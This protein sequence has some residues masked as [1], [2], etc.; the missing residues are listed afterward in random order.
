MDDPDCIA[1]S[2]AETPSP[3]GSFTSS[4]S[5]GPFA[6]L[7]S[8]AM[9]SP[10]LGIGSSTESTGSPGPSSPASSRAGGGASDGASINAGDS[11]SN[12]RSESLTSSVPQPADDDSDSVVWLQPSP[13]PADPGSDAG[14]SSSHSQSEQ[15]PHR[16]FPL[17][18]QPLG[19][20]HPWGDPW[21]SLTLAPIVD[22]NAVPAAGV[23]YGQLHDPQR[24]ERQ[25]RAADRIPSRGPERAATT[26]GPRR[27]DELVQVSWT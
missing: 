21:G 14:G 4:Y 18:L 22:Y 1:D 26:P 10:S 17:A 12:S 25:R 19:G 23:D 13:T 27:G 24:P 9:A 15:R 20:Q 8:P 5:D 6:S 3:M 2:S 11:S 16:P 7:S